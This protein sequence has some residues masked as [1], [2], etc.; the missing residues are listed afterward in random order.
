MI[1][2]KLFS[3]N[4]LFIP[5]FTFS[6]NCVEPQSQ[7]YL[8]ANNVSTK[9]LNG[10]D[11]WRDLS[12]Q[13]YV[14]PKPPSGGT[15]V[16]ALFASALWIGG[17]DDAGNLKLAAQTYRQNGDDYWAG[18][19]INGSAPTCAEWD[20][21][22]VVYGS[23]ITLIRSD[24]MADGIVDSV[25]I[26]LLKWPGR[27][28]PYYQ[29][30]FPNILPNQ[31]LAPFH[32]ED[33]DG[34][35]D[36]YKGDFPIIGLAGCDTLYADQMVW[37]VINDIGN[38]HGN[39]GSDQIGIEVQMMAYS[40]VSPPLDYS[41]FYN[42]KV[43]NKKP[44]KLNNTHIS[45]WVHPSLGCGLNDFVGCNVPR[46]MGIVYNGTAT[47][48]ACGSGGGY[49]NTIPLIGIDLLQGPKDDNGIELGMTSFTYYNN[50]PGPQGNPSQGPEYYGY[51]TGFWRDGSSIQQGGDGYNQGTTIAP[52]VYPGNPNDPNSWSEC[53]VGNMP[54]ER[55]F[56]MTAG[57]FTLLPG[58][59]KELTMGVLYA[60][61]VAHPCPDFQPLFEVSDTIQSLFDNCFGQGL[62]VSNES[63]Q[64]TN[65]L[66]QLSLFPNPTSSKR[67]ISLKHFSQN[68]I[69]ELWSIDGV[70][71]FQLA[72]EQV[73]ETSINLSDLSTELNSGLY[74]LLVKKDGITE[75]FAKL[76]IID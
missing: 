73:E 17:Y 59:I 27:G 26:N 11:M 76:S 9:L 64:S 46:S 16:N 67:S 19:I 35:Y 43:I 31:D 54:G 63:L 39:S 4:L 1:L 44:T 13:S 32:D 45:I 8:D 49:D 2:K 7:V 53:S 57:P 14:V 23:E 5:F 25:P 33:N 47:D 51:M 24:F 75:Q 20:Q 12:S 40:F 66:R 50:D 3:L 70:L 62:P 28:N 52:H 21:H 65:E 74:F 30:Y 60:P 36:P 38:V 48:P 56:L 22:Y 42:Y 34:L 58:A 71:L 10:G 69:I 18:P 68:S 55:R 41:T 6:Q 37:W 29:N 61:D 72:T 15:G